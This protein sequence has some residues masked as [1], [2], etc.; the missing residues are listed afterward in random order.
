MPHSFVTTAAA[1]LAAGLTLA[2]VVGTASATAPDPVG[3]WATP[4]SGGIVEIER[5][6]DA[7][8]GAL[9]T[10]PYLKFD[11]NLR[12]RKNPDASKR[13]RLLKGLAL[14]SGFQGGGGK[15]TDGTLYNP[16]NGVVYTA[17][18]E[19]LSVDRIRVRGCAPA[20]FCKVQI[21]TRAAD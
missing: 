17:S 16:D 6:G 20:H 3:L 21:W 12:D 2:S 8:C 11:P 9:V 15:W 5:C 18:L 1:I 14:M 19:V 10:S 13:E 7:M 4:S